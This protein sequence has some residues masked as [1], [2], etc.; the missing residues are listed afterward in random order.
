MSEKHE[1]ENVIIIHGKQN[2]NK[3]EEIDCAE[4]LRFNLFPKEN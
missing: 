1:N 3:E 2:R 4:H